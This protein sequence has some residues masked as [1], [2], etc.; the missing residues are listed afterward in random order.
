[1]PLI[2]GLD[3]I[4]WMLIFGGVFLAGWVIKLAWRR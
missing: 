4:Q 2:L 3:P 1:M